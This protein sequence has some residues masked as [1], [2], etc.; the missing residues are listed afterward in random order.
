MPQSIHYIANNESILPALGQY[1]RERSF[2]W[3][4]YCI[5]EAPVAEYLFIVE[6]FSI[7]TELYAISST[8]KPWLMEFQP[9]IRLIVAAY[10]RTQN[11]NCLDLLDLPNDLSAWLKKTRPMSDFP[12]V[13][14]NSET[15]KG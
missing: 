12:L 14:A 7:G 11:P 10:S 9:N 6:P 3:V 1:F 13:V 4:K 15:G 2:D 8:W 5:N